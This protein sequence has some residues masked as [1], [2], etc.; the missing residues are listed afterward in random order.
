MLLTQNHG[1]IDYAHPVEWLIMGQQLQNWP[2]RRSH[3]LKGYDYTKPGSYFVTIS[4]WRRRNLF[5]RVNDGR[6]MPNQCGDIAGHFW[7]EITDHFVSVVLDEFVVMP[8]HVH[9]LIFLS[10]PPGRGQHA[11]PRPKRPNN[12][13][14]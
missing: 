11:G 12:A 10:A 3:R 1:W 4:T 7:S 5:G 13:E 6:M 2:V 9:G 8:N 14:G